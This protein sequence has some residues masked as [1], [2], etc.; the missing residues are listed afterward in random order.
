MRK[1]NVDSLKKFR[2]HLQKQKLR[3]LDQCREIIRNNPENPPRIFSNHAYTEIDVILPSTDMQNHSYHNQNHH[4]NSLNSFNQGS[5]SKAIFVTSNQQNKQLLGVN[6]SLEKPSVG[7]FNFNDS[8]FN[9]NNNMG[10]RAT[11]SA[12]SSITKQQQH[13]I[14][15][16]KNRQQVNVIISSVR[17]E[18][19]TDEVVEKLTRMNAIADKIKRLR[20]IKK[21]LQDTKIRINQSMRNETGVCKCKMQVLR[22][23]EH[24][25]DS[26]NRLPNSKDL[27][28][29]QPL[30][31]EIKEK[32]DEIKQKHQEQ[33]KK[34]AIEHIPRP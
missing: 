29:V 31:N 11:Q 19:K 10:I 21:Q 3:H 17:I 24:D 4:L 30:I 18:D 20:Q 6:S 27:E 26:H 12:T 8:N 9:I 23:C 34:V 15:P 7:L 28:K 33:P 25:Q 1:I 32:L 2:R 14:N 13:Q 5:N 16:E 22:V